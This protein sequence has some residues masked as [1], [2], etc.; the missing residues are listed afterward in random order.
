MWRWLLVLL[1]FT[2]LAQTAPPANACTESYYKYVISTLAHDS[3]EGRLPGT[4]AEKKCAAFIVN[5]FKRSGCRPL[6]P[7]KYLYP[8]TYLNPD[9][10]PTLTAGNIIAKIETK[11]KRCIIVGAHYDHIGMGKHHSRAPFAKAIHNGADDNASGVA[12]LLSLAAWCRQHQKEMNYDMI[13]V[14]YAA[15]EDGLW[16]S[17]EL[18]KGRL[19]D[20]A[21]IYTYLN[22]DMLGSLNQ[23]NP[24]LKT[25]GLLEYPELD[26]ALPPDSTAGFNIRKYDPIFTGGSDNYSF[27]LHHIPGIAFSTGL[28]G[29]YHRPGDDADL[30]NYQGMVKI[31][32][33]LKGVIMGLQQPEI[34]IK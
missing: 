13:F 7:K 24:I 8:F 18:L 27:Q 26:S 21:T 29:Q 11:S 10:L 2:A 1:P 33:Y 16:G 12:M 28:T 22:F 4:T 31:S 5:E 3:M 23:L 20:T 25:E 19:I 15:E 17:A 32:A 9:T 14:A 30:I 34:T 6:A